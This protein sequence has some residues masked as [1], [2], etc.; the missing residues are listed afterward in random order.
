[1]NQTPENLTLPYIVSGY[2]TL[3]GVFY[4]VT[5]MLNPPFFQSLSPGRYILMTVAAILFAAGLRYLLLVKKGELKDEGRSVF[6][7]RKKAIEKAED[8]A[9]LAQIAQNDPVPEIREMAKKK[10]KELVEA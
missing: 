8:P 4:L 3:A 7:I 6:E 1:M 2:V 9:F 10:T 5:P